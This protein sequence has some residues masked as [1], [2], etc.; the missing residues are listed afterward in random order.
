MQPLRILQICNK[1]PVPAVDGGCL[2]MLRMTEGLLDAGCKIHLLSIATDKHPWHPEK[3]DQQFIKQTSAD[4]VYV[5]TRVK[6][7]PAFLS[8]FKSDSHNVERFYSLGF[9][10]RLIEILSRNEFDIVQL[11]SLYVT[12]YIR[13]IR[14]MSKAKIVLRAHNTE[15]AIWRKNAAE[16]KSLLKRKWFNDLAGKLENHEISALQS[17]DAVVPITNEDCNRLKILCACSKPFHTATFAMKQTATET[18]SLI[19]SKTVF[20]IGAMDWQPNV[21]GIDWF[22]EKVWPIVVQ[23]VPEASLHLAGKAMD[24]SMKYEGANIVVHGEVQSAKDFLASHR[25]MIAP[26]LSGG[27]VKVKV[28]EGMLAGKPIVTTRIGA[29][30]I[31]FQNGFD[32]FVTEDEQTFADNVVKLLLDDTAASQMSENA[33]KSASENHDLSRVTK[34][35]CDFYRTIIDA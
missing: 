28:I 10:A 20:H 26:L 14:R 5:D 9:E 35:L 22:V 27:G 4:A 3:A 25:V 7:L 23:Q 32:L 6:R 2:A 8:L 17:V 21:V 12:P 31:Q 24:K 19:K 11:E 33:M 34:N 29:E 18:V 16:E 15:S 1:P 30:G 13:T